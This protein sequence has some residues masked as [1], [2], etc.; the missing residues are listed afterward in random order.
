MNKNELALYGGTPVTKPIPRKS[1]IGSEELA[2]AETVVKNGVLSGFRGGASVRAFEQAFAEYV[3]TKYAVATTS[4]TT[5]L[6]ASVASLGLKKGDEVLVPALT[7][8]STAS[9]AL[10]EG[11]T[12]VFVDIDDDYCMD[13]QDLKSKIT[14]KSKAIIPVHLYGRPAQMEEIISIAKEHNLVVIE[15]ACQ[16]HGAEYE[17][18]KA[19]NLGDIG[20]F[21]FFETKNMTCGEGGMVTTSDD[22]LYRQICLRR[23]HGSPRNT[24]TWYAYNVLGYNYNMT[25]VQGAIGKVQLGKLDAMNRGRV[26][27]AQLYYKYLADLELTLPPEPKRS[28]NVYHNFP[29]LLPEKYREK[30]DLFIKAMQAEGIPIDVAYPCTLYQTK[31]FIDAGITG[32][33]PRAEDISSR[34]FT[35]FTDNAIDEKVII[36]T[37][38]AIKKV[39]T[40]FENH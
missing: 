39:F 17:G 40:Y 33:C 26:D 1:S 25:E 27:N 11:L 36:D 20:C 22:E 35:L 7:F 12:V 38:E 2:A 23:E 34:L 13:V 5:A 6:H 30:R 29:V 16:A 32:D 8:V 14:E 15:D 21:S 3:G 24:N 28:T 9:V 31:L 18:K 19:G 10:Q 37:V 4:G